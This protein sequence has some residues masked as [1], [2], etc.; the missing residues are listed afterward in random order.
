MMVTYNECRLSNIIEYH[1]RLFYP[2]FYQFSERIITYHHVQ[3]PADSITKV[4]LTHINITSH[5]H[6]HGQFQ[7]FSSLLSILASMVGIF[8]TTYKNQGEEIRNCKET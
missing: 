7:R 4:L 6:C 2:N 3:D 8:K 5:F 1:T